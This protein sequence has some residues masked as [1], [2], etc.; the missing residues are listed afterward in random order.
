VSVLRSSSPPRRALLALAAVLL[1][2]GPTA[3]GGGDDDAGGTTT[4]PPATTAS[5]VAKAPRLKTGDTKQAVGTVSVCG[6]VSGMRRLRSAIR[7]F[8]GVSQRLQASTLGFPDGDGR[9]LRAFE[10][11]QRAGSRDCDVYVA[12]RADE[13]PTLAADGDLYDLAPA[14][15]GWSAAPEAPPLAPVRDGERAFGLPIRADDARGI[16]VV[17]VHGRNPGG[18][19]ELVRALAD[20]RVTDG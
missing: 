1:V 19:L 20:A 4:A 14:L 12:E 17:S 11:R 3:C 7:R 8:D 2:A 5:T 16:L 13:V 6:S 15:E 9:P 10:A 18:A